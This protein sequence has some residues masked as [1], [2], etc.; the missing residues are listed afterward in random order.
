[1]A[2]AHVDKQSKIVTKPKPMFEVV[3]KGLV[4]V[5]ERV[6]FGILVDV[7]ICNY[8]DYANVIRTCAKDIVSKFMKVR[9]ITL[10]P[11]LKIFLASSETMTH[12][13][14]MF[15]NTHQYE[16]YEVVVQS[17]QVR[18]LTN[19]CLELCLENF[20]VEDHKAAKEEEKIEYRYP[21][22]AEHIDPATKDLLFDAWRLAREEGSLVRC[23]AKFDTQ[24]RQLSEARFTYQSVLD[25]GNLHLNVHPPHNII[26][27]QN[28]TVGN[29]K[30][31]FYPSFVVS[32]SIT[33]EYLLP[34]TSKL[35]MSR[36]EVSDLQHSR[37]NKNFSNQARPMTNPRK[38]H[39][40]TKRSTINAIPNTQK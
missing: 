36:S 32:S 8:Y 30:H 6:A 23:P 17:N 22:Y 15:C 38:T 21:Q 26:I 14:T 11:G 35:S 12:T 7:S 33:L 5:H 39:T 20:L 29:C 9:K 13:G 24:G 19:M 3:K 2:V 16:R 10:V 27:T 25:P 18:S 31:F 1:M 37:Q 40:P 28:E 4:N 34:F